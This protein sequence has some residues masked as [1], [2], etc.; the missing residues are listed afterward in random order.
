MPA[1]AGIHADFA[2]VAGSPWAPAFAGATVKID[3]AQDYP[4]PEALGLASEG[5]DR[6][7]LV[8]DPDDGRRGSLKQIKPKWSLPY[9]HGIREVQRHTPIFTRRSTGWC[10]KLR[11]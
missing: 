8:G 7:P 1:K 2:K 10:V 6:R 4:Q 9:P 5:G 11:P 3:S